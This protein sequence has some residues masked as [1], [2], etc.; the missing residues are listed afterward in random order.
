MAYYN[1]HV[2]GYYNLLHT[3]NDRGG[4][5]HC[6][7]WNG[8]LNLSGWCSTPH[9]EAPASC[10]CYTNPSHRIANFYCK[11]SLRRFVSSMQMQGS[12]WSFLAAVHR[13]SRS[14]IDAVDNPILSNPLILRILGF[15]SSPF[16]RKLHHPWLQI[17]PPISPGCRSLY[18]HL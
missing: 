7:S 9:D 8:S 5:D 15:F 12:R 4:F 3:A 1:S 18:T 16:S 13:R 2:T 17:A 11:A 6:S 10:F 14:K